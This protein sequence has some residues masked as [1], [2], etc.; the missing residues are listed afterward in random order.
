M[1]TKSSRSPLVSRRALLAGGFWSAIGL[2]MVGLLGVPLSFLRPR[3]VTG[4]GGRVTVPAAKVPAPGSEPVHIPEGKFFLANLALGKEESPGGLLA[5]WHKCPHLGC[6]VPWRPDFDYDGTKGWY[7]CPCHGSTYSK[8][9]GLLA[10][11]PS[12]RP[13]DTMAIKVKD[14]GDVVVNTEVITKGGKDNPLRAV[15]YPWA[16]ARIRPSNERAQKA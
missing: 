2:A 14:N 12:P 8:G 7:R 6:A 4:L 10:F 3:N 15:P 5:L 16:V 9:G 11:G 13:L 1:G